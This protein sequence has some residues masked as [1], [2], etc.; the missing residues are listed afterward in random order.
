MHEMLVPPSLDLCLCVRVLC[1]CVH[2]RDVVCCACA[3]ARAR[4]CVCVC[5]LVFLHYTRKMSKNFMTG[6][7][8]YYSAQA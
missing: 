1:A 2:A 8:N 3:R 5:F 4:V 7:Y 6:A